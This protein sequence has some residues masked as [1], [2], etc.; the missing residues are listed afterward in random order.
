MSLRSI[1]IL[2]SHLCLDLPK[3]VFPV[4]LPV[5]IWKHSY[6]L[7]FWLH[8]LSILILSLTILDERYK[9]R[10]SSLWSF[11]HSPFS[12]CLGSNICFRILFSNTLRPLLTKDT[13]FH[14]HI[15]ELAYLYILMFDFLGKY[16]SGKR[17][18]Q[19]TTWAVSS[20]CAYL[21]SQPWLGFDLLYNLAPLVPIFDHVVTPIFF[22]CSSTFFIHIFLRL[23][24]FLT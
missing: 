15:A 18:T 6:L 3:N 2:S 8:D 1:I 23:P 21:A 5:R 11:L 7:P 19:N 14:N 9:L 13:M 24:L 4:I 22:K 12:S 20:S 17:N 10:S 16:I